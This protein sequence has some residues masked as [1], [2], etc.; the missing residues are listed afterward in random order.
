MAS[1]TQTPTQSKAKA[2]HPRGSGNDLNSDSRRLRDED[3]LQ[4]KTIEDSFPASDPP[5]NTPIS[6]SGRTNREVPVGMKS[7]F[8]ENGAEQFEYGRRTEA[9]TFNFDTS[10]NRLRR[11]NPDIGNVDLGNIEADKPAQKDDD[12]HYD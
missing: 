9:K 1:N 8:K 12:D 6:G 3:N 7:D 11:G 4:D 2:A 5:S 10:T